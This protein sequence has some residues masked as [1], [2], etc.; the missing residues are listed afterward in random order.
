MGLVY[1][2]DILVDVAGREIRRQPAIEPW[3]IDKWLRTRNLRSDTWLAHRECVMKTNLHDEA[4]EFDEDYD[5]FYQL[6]KITTFSHLPEYLVYIR[7]H[8]GQTT[9]NRL[10]LAK[11]HAANL[12]KYGYSPEYAYLRARHNPEWVPAIEEGIALGKKLREKRDRA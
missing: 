7:R 8:P 3:S 9:A 11:C 12:V 6:L 1:A 10:E 4:L 2:D 5:L